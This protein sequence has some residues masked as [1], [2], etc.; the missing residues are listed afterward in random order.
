MSWLIA[1]LALWTGI[2]RPNSNVLLLSKGEDEAG[3][4][5]GKVSFLLLHLPAH[6]RPNIVNANNSEIIFGFDWDDDMKKYKQTSKIEALPATA[7]AGRSQTATLVLL[8][9]W[10]F[11]PYAEKNY[12][13]IQPTIDKGGSKMIAVSTANGSG[14]YF[15]VVYKNAQR[16]LGNFARIFLPY[17]ARPGRD[18]AW[19]KEKQQNEYKSSPLL[20]FQEFPR[21]EDEAFI[22]SGGCIFNMENLNAMEKECE[23][24]IDSTAPNIRKSLMELMDEYGVQVFRRPD[25]GH[26]YIMWTDPSSAEH[27][28][29]FSCH[30]VM[31]VET[32]EDVATWWGKMADDT[33]AHIGFQ[34]ARIYNQAYWG[35]ERTGVGNSILNVAI[36]QLNYPK[37]RLYHHR[38][39]NKKKS[40]QIQDKTP[41]MP[42]TQISNRQMESIGKSVV[43]HRRVKVYNLQL[44]LEMKTLVEDPVTRKVE[45]KAPD[46]DDRVRCWLGCLWLR[47][48]PE[49]RYS[50]VRPVSPPKPTPQV[51]RRVMRRRVA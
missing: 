48:L 6:L 10:A 16:G 4:L 14:N 32:G 31:D 34:L 17:D 20:L 50:Q 47:E 3:K 26:R 41:G 24:P 36:N 38:D 51:K 9:E 45:A 29:D 27:G 46:N 5:L 11:H 30:Q 33:V 35:I 43:A 49:A 44:L 8:D 7:D 39:I 23:P 25:P 18:E 21:F 37:H 28:R 40:D 22:A 19:W 42:A 13:A 2:F 1:L 15:A 12:A